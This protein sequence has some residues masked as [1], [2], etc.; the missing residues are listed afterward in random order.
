MNDHQSFQR[1]AAVTAIVSF[2]LTLA[3][4][5]LSTLPTINFI[6]PD[7]ATN[8]AH[9]LGDYLPLLP[10]F[11]HGSPLYALFEEHPTGFG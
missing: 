11:Q 7:I 9:M 10:H 4:V 8:P 3:S 2:P 5:V 1:F 6:S